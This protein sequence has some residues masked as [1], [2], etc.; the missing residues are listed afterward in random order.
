[1]VTGERLLQLVVLPPAC[2]TAVEA[3]FDGGGGRLLFF[4]VAWG[5]VSL[6]HCG[7]PARRSGG[8]NVGRRQG[9]NRTAARWQPSV[10]LAAAAAAAQ[11]SP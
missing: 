10:V 3:A 7:V 2:G 9:A 11:R 6:H 5:G 8:G 4:S 1:M